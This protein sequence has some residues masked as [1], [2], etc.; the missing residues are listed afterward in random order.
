MLEHWGINRFW[1]PFHIK[2]LQIQTN[3]VLLLRPKQEK[4]LQVFKLM[5]P[6][7]FGGFSTVR[8]WSPKLQFE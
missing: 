5:I 1:G 2:V 6:E 3:H 7:S 8:L 4:K